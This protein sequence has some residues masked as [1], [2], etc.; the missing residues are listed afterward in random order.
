LWSGCHEP[1]RRTFLS[2]RCRGA[3]H[4]PRLLLRGYNCGV[5]SHVRDGV[6]TRIEGNPDH[7][8]NCGRLCAKGLA[9]TRFVFNPRRLIHPLK[10][11]GPRGSGEFERISWDEAMAMLTEKLAETRDG[12]GP[13]NILLSIG[14]ASIW[15]GLHHLLML[16]FLHALGSPNFTPWSP[17][18]CCS[19]QL[20][21]HKLTAGGPS[22]ARPDC[23]NADLIIEWFT[24]GGQGGP[25]RGG[26][27]TLDTNLR[28]LPKKIL[29]RIEKGA[30]LVVINPQLIPLAANGRAHRWM[31][32]RPGTGR[33][34]STGA[35][36]SMSLPPTCAPAPPPGPR[37]SPAFRPGRSRSLQGSTLPPRGRRSGGPRRRRSGTRR[38]LVR[39]SP[40]SSPSPDTW[41]ARAATFGFVLPPA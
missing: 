27:E 19:P 24:G 6:M 40:C 35:R 11:K 15:I 30:R 2:T 18:I 22:Y 5:L 10:R 31:P 41:T 26:V 3:H 13:E 1:K 16:R 29:D 14:Q 9:A 34:S 8:L 28:S 4:V 20:F 25:P 7:P 12:P 38:P 36:D 39:P 17:Y 21:Y 37:P 33:S 23:D 32:I